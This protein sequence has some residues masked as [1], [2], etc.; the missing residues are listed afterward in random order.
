V[1]DQIRQ[2]CQGLIVYGQKFRQILS[3]YSNIPVERIYAVPHGE[4]K[5]YTYFDK[6]EATHGNGHKNVLFFGR[7]EHYKGIDLLVD[8][9][10]MIT[11]R[12]P[13]AQIV[14]AGEGRLPFSDLEPRIVHRDKFV[15]K[16]YSIPDEEV[17]ELFKNADVVV[18]P[19]REATQSGPLHI[20]GSFARPS[21]VTAVGAMTEVVKDGE[22]GILVPPEDTNQLAEAICR[23]L[24]NPEEAER[25]GQRAYEVMAA[26]ES[27][28]K[29]AEIQ[30]KAY[31][32]VIEASRKR[33][34]QTLIMRL[35][36]SFVK[37]V[38]RD[39]NYALD[40]T[41]RFGDLIAML[42][43]LGLGGFRG[44][45]H[46]PFLDAVRGLCF[47]GH[48]VKLRNRKHIRLGRNFVAEDGCEV[49]GLSKRG[50]VF[51]D[52]VTVGSYSMIRPSGYYGREIGEGLEIG[53]RSN[54]GPYCY[55]G[56]S[57]GIRIGADVMMGPRVSLFAEN[58][59]FE[60]TDVTM[61]EQ[62]VSRQEIVI[63]DDCWLASGS[64]IL[65][66][67]TIGKGS[68]VAAGAVVTRDVPPYSIVGGN[69]ARVIRSRKE[70]A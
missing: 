4:Y 33:G 30:A 16:N 37:Q 47:I 3:D 29:V 60:S 36:Q 63:E 51:G 14:L 54:V 46:R 38:K 61:R 48:R 15:V 44:L 20:A 26:E 7:W 42:G 43:K 28:E 64:V 23:L 35:M 32:N 40:E 22:T 55:L 6:G 68:I 50:I 58:H 53:D 1:R 57:G 52:N 27:M 13:E 45:Y 17:P 41:L 25:M 31:Q 11:E 69:P 65:A 24:E 18:L 9:E 59:N 70:E 49:Q 56:A 34:G 19:Y 67:V 8:A 21:V 39:P 10:P 5:F 12:V 2:N 62:G 66:G